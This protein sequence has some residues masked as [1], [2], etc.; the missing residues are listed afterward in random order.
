MKLEIWC[1]WA[2]PYKTIAKFVVHS[3]VCT[4]RTYT[5]VRSLVNHLYSLKLSET[6]HWCLTSKYLNVDTVSELVYSPG[7]HLIC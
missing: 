3:I 4:F 2:H 6:S 5:P 7:E 1:G